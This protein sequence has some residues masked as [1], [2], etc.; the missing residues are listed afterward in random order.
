MEKNQIPAFV[1]SLNQTIANENLGWEAGDNYLLELSEEEQN[2]YLGYAPG[3]DEESFE[4]IERLAKLSYDAE[5][6]GDAIGDTALATKI[7]WRNRRGSNYVTPVKNQGACG[8]C[9][10]F[11]VVATMENRIRVIANEPT[12]NIDL[13]EAHLFYCHARSEGRNCGNGWWCHKGL[14]A[15]KKKGVVDEACYPY[16]GRDQNCTGLCSNWKN[17][18]VKI[19]DWKA[20]TSRTAMKQAIQDHGALVGRFN[21]Y[22]DF[23]AYKSG[24]YKKSSGASFRGGHCISVVGY[25]D[26]NNC[27]ICKNSWGQ[28][29]GEKHPLVA[30]KGYFRIG[31]GQVGIDAKMWKI[32]YIPLWLYNKKVTGLWAINQNKNAWVHLHGI[33]WRK[34][35]N[36]ND[37]AFNLMLTQLAAAKGG[38]RPVH[39]YL[40]DGMISQ[41]YVL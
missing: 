10:A 6:T 23:F 22:S 2:K 36:K 19:R 9:V 21:V 5:M 37:S 4:E 15:A 11:G 18:L 32:T 14:D 12:R 8:S 20:I 29:W 34:I 1:S 7:D 13:S 17:R 39:L 25:D 30:E 35:W 16:V 26:T 31:Y 33:G 3:P 24:V 38:N 27:W 28:N 40:Y 41:I